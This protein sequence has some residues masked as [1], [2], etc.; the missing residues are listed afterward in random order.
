M[1]A[2]TVGTRIPWRW[3][4]SSGKPSWILERSGKPRAGSLPATTLPWRGFGPYL[5]PV[6]EELTAALRRVLP[7]EVQRDIGVDTGAWVSRTVATC[8]RLS[9]PELAADVGAFAERRD[10]AAA[11]HKYSLAACT[12]GPLT[13]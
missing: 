9:A 3:P 6:P 7:P 13:R 1:S 5:D 8:L 4:H 2:S 12:S 10:N 11:E